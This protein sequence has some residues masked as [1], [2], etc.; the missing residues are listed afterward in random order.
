[1]YHTIQTLRTLGKSQRQIAAGLLTHVLFFLVFTETRASGFIPGTC[2]IFP[3][4][5]FPNSITW[6]IR[7]RGVLVAY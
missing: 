1:M 2:R 6:A 5:R 3:K 4:V 7:L